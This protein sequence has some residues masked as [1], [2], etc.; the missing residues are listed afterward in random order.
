MVGRYEHDRTVSLTG[1]VGEHPFQPG[2]RRPL[3]GESVSSQILDTGRSVSSDPYHEMSGTIAAAARSAGMRAGV[4]APVIVDGRIWGNVTVGGTDRAPLPANIER[5]LTQFTEL[6]ATAVS[7]AQ[8]RQDLR[9][10]AEEQAALRRVATEVAEGATPD[11]IFG[12]VAEEIA[13]VTGL[14][15]IVIGRFEPDRTMTPIGAVGDH[16]YQPG[17]RWPLDGGNV[18]GRVLDTG[19]PV[20][21]DPY[22]EMTGTIAEAAHT[23]GIHAGVGAPIIVEGRVWGTVSAA[24]TERVPLPPNIEHRVTAFTELVAMSVSNAQA[25]QEVR[26]LLDEQAALRRIATLVARGAESQVV[27]DAVCEETGRL[28]GAATVNLVYFTPDDCHLAMSGWSLRRVHVPAGTGERRRLSPSRRRRFPRRRQAE[29]S[30]GGSASG[31]TIVGW[32][33]DI[34]VFRFPEIRSWTGRSPA[35]APSS[36]RILRPRRSSTISPSEAPLHSRRTT[37]RKSVPATSS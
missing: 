23:A 31:Y 28:F 15:W 6:I 37:T 5:R 32:R 35:L 29:L 24:G 26:R 25:R 27:F 4:G 21:V 11:R 13:R 36:D 30:G 19:R 14:E 3:D 9:R 1:A 18:S 20:T 33:V 7:N 34:H 10:L 22:G 2:T 8:A 16:P 12:L 17:T